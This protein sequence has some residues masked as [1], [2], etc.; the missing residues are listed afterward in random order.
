[1][2]PGQSSSP[3][4]AENPPFDYFA[5]LKREWSPLDFV[6]LALLAAV[7]ATF[8]YFYGVIRIYS[9]MPISLWAW[10]RYAPQYNFEHGKLVPIIFAFLVWYHRRELVAAEKKGSNVGLLVVVLGCLCYA[11]GARTLQGRFALFA[12]PV[13][14]YGV[15]LF[16]LGKKV[17]RIL[18]F[19][20]VF[21]LFMI[22]VAAIEQAT[23]HLQFM[24]TGLANVVCNA[25]GI[26]IFAV[27][28]TL[29]AVDDS[30][31]FD[32]AEGCSGIRSLM[33][34][35]MVTSVYVH[36]TQTEFWKKAVILLFSTGFAIIGNAG[37]IVTLLMVAKFISPQ[38]AGGLYHEYSGFLFFPIALGS[39][40]AFSRLLE[41]PYFEAA[42]SLKAGAI[43][44]AAPPP[45]PE[46]G[47]DQRPKKEDEYDY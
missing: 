35:I 40:L 39:M 5:F 21:L 8:W 9:G 46:A 36:L 6:K 23:F 13:L 14:L 44:P 10:G 41:L 2:A 43:A 20:I 28:T 15:I 47:E 12:A 17:A 16:L 7:C 24:I 1:M 19:P 37:R 4:G 18:L 42:R 27:G 45:K 34:M 22:P 29:R 30:F 38:L 11:I 3:P 33:A 31:G 25:I 26:K 32:I